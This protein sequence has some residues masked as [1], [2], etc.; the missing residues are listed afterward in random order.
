VVTFLQ[1]RKYNRKRIRGIF[2][3]DASGRWL[4]TTEDV[5][6]AGLDN[7]DRDYFQYHRVNTDRGTLI[8]KPVKSRSGGQWIITAWRRFNHPDGSFAGVV[9]TSIDVAY[10]AE[11]YRRFDIGPNGAVSLLNTGGIMLARSGD[12]D[13][14]YVGRDMSGSPLFRTLNSRPEA[15]V[16]YFK[17]PL[18]GRQRLSFYRVSGHYPIVILA[19]KAQDDV[20]APWREQAIMRMGIVT[21]L[22]LALAL[23]GLLSFG[24]CRSDN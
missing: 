24:T 23:I 9:L 18:D 10:F 17:S 22:T 6:I 12:D 19:T 4:A 15:S 13:G 8:G 1:S 16:Y 7:S 3:Y 14:A 5:D 20:L 2:V 11:F 21:G